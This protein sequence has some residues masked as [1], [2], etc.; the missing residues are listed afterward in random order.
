[1]EHKLE[2]E[3]VPMKE[4]CGTSVPEFGLP[5]DNSEKIRTIRRNLQSV[6]ISS[7]VSIFDYYSKILSKI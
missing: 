1:M 3:N 2:T 7:I 4:D 6:L 5:A